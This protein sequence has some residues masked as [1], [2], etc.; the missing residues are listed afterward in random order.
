MSVGNLN[1]TRYSWAQPTE[2]PDP[3]WTIYFDKE[4]ETIY[5]EFTCF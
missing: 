3:F 5:M 1:T 2:A 4:Q